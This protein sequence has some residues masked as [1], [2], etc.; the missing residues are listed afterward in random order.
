MPFRDQRITLIAHDS[1]KPGLDW[2]HAWTN[3]QRVAF[4]ESIAAVRSALDG[5]LHQDIGI[6]VERVVIDRAGD[7]DS[8][9]NLLAGVPSEFGGDL[10]FIRQDGCGFLSAMGRGGDR[11]FYALGTR[12]VRFYLEMHDLVTGRAALKLSA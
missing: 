6:D 3:T 7:A 8:F 1:S 2:N 10:L 11:V 9:L 4:L 12:D 5:A